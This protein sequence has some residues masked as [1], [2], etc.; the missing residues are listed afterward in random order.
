MKT[1][2]AT[3]AKNRFGEHF[4]FSDRES[5]V[6]E[7][8]GTPTHRV[9]TAKTGR[10]LVLAGFSAGVLSAGEAMDLLGIDWYGDLLDALAEE[11]VD[12]PDANMTDKDRE[13]LERAR[14]LLDEIL[15]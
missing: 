2:S 13:A 8:H 9:F 10:R 6:I 4:N 1:I 3:E 12:R 11:H 15:E 5:L 14:P 7:T